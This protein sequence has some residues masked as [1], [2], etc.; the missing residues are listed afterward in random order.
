MRDD[1]VASKGTPM[2]ANRQKT[3]KKRAP[4]RTSWAKGVSGNPEGRKA[5]AQSWSGVLRVVTEKN[6]EELSEMVGGKATDLGRQLLRLP[7][8]VPLKYL[9]GVRA[10][11]ALMF[12]PSGSLLRILMDAEQVADLDDRLEELERAVMKIDQGGPNL[13]IENRSLHSG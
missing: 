8:G 2:P 10:L 6:A 1:K 3:G 5:E 4:T 7:N 9:I 13:Y 12:E 11:L